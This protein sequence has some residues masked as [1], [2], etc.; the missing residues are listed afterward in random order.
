[1]LQT[2]LKY[3][4]YKQ[5][6][7]YICFDD[8]DVKFKLNR[9]KAILADLIRTARDY[10]SEYNIKVLLFVRE[11]LIKHLAGVDS[12]ISKILDSSQ[13][14]LSWYQHDDYQVDEK[15]VNLRNLKIHNDG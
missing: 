2:V 7:F 4:V 3:D 9:D 12:D 11:D 13:I 10:N 8:I 1:M 14:T 15:N 5:S 6:T